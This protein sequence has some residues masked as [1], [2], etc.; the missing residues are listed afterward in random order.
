MDYPENWHAN[1]RSTGSTQ[2]RPRSGKFAGFVVFAILVFSPF[3]S[4]CANSWDEV[5]SRDFKM[6]NLFVTPDPLVVLRDSQDGDKRAKALRALQEP[7]QHGGAEA[8]QDAVLKIVVSAA[9]TEKQPL[10]RLAAIETLGRF[11]D[12]RAVT[13][14]TNAFYN[15][16][17][18]APETSTMLRCHALRALGET[19]D[20]A[21]VELLVRVVR[22][23]PAQGAEVDRQ[24]ALDVRTAAARALSNFSQPQAA[25]ALV[26]VLKTEKD[27]AL[28]DCAHG[29]LEVATG[30]KLSQD[31]KEWDDAIQQAG[32]K[33]SNSDS[34]I[35][36]MSN[37]ITETVSG[38]P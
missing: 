37:W 11:K 14:L 25:E 13:G 38:S 36:R 4:G 23:P 9:T 3:L 8:D 35:K 26:Q 33:Q 32:A 22:E 12:P 2:D 10:C 6:S 20:P 30:K 17:S 1:H 19:K 31:P 16:A 29:S 5:T 27:V 7:K 24:Q 15:A 34:P 18:F 28:R 21:A